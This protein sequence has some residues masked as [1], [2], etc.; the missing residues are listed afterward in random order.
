MSLSEIFDYRG[1]RY[2]IIKSVEIKELKG[3]G[4]L[5]AFAR[6]DVNITINDGYT[7]DF[8]MI[9][10]VPILLY[11]NKWPALPEI[12]YEPTKLNDGY[13]YGFYFEKLVYNEKEL[14]PGSVVPVR[15]MVARV[16]KCIRLPDQNT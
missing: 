4:G 2:E 9:S 13:W 10:K 6:T 8:G 3:D 5:F 16:A 1:R 15:T 11:I 12:L 14:R 7:M